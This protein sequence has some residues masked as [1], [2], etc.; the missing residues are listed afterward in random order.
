MMN[1]RSA[2]E[3]FQ[4]AVHEQ[5]GGDFGYAI[6]LFEAA[7]AADDPEW[8]PRA[9]ATLGEF[10]W[11]LENAVAPPPLNHSVRMTQGPGPHATFGDADL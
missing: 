7:I 2:Q 6:E 10:L 4:A 1:A 9:A 5:H 3:T 8:S 11:D